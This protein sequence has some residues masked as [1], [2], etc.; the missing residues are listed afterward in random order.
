MTFEVRDVRPEELAEAGAVTVAAYSEFVRPGDADWEAYV[1]EL[2]NVEARAAR[3]VVLVAV[4]EPPGVLGTVTL[5]LSSRIDEDFEP[6]EPDRAHVRM[7]AVRPEAR[8]RGVARA[9]MEAC[10]DRAR[11]AGKRRLTLHTTERMIAA[12][13]MYARLGFARSE[14]HVFPNGF[15]L[16]GY[17]L[18]L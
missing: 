13:A 1:E 3:A 10:A 6:L 16:L 14:D 17:E 12:Q 18:K 15:V 8:R 4:E 7:L 11:A 5:E 9:L 2:R